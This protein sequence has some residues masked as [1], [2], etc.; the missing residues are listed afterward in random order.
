M[1]RIPVAGPWVT[2][3]EMNSVA[4]AARDAWYS[5]AGSYTRSFEEE[6]AAYIGVRHAISLPSCTAGLHLAL[7]AAGV[8]PGDEVIVPD[9]TWIASSAPVRYVGATEVFA[10]VDPTT[11]CLDARLFESLITR[12]TRA[13]I[14][15]D[16]YGGLPAMDEIRKIAAQHNI[17]VIEDSAEA[18]GSEVRGARAGSLGDAGVFSFHGSKTLT[19]GE[20][21]MLVTDRH[22][23]YQRATFLRDHGRRP[24]DTSF[25]NTE[26]AYKYRMSDLQAAFG[27][28]QLRRIHELVGK[29]RQIFDWYRARLAN[30]SRITLNA[31]P[32]GTKNSYWM[33]TALVDPAL[34]ISKDTLQR[35][36]GEQ[37]IAT[38]PFF[39][40]LSSLPAYAESAQA[41]LAALRNRTAYSI[42]ATGI[43]LPSALCLEEEQVD[44]VCTA[45]TK[46][47]N[48]ANIE[49]TKAA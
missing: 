27:L 47:L 38:R 39:H 21:G 36:L 42:S 11:W 46:I 25:F 24:G 45:L 9:L 34:G 12:R 1:D 29:K 8:G 32:Q 20:G 19:T 15:V 33:V 14:P 23:I 6:F 28:A 49:R 41:R 13:V 5:E 43:N 48:E 18:I 40:P 7:A 44:Q 4:A 31:E 22:D 26:V 3:D 35:K 10:D 16:L 30:D 17:L 37:G 2:T